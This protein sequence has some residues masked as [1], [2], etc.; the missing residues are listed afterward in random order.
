MEILILICTIFS[1]IGIVIAYVCGEDLYAVAL[2]V[3]TFILAIVYFSELID[4]YH[5]N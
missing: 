5:R 3:L 4:Y 2:A 1:A